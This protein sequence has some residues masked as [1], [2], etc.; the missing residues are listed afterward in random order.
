MGWILYCLLY[1]FLAGLTINLGYHRCLAHRSLRLPRFLESVLITFG[2]P[3]GTPI[4]WAGNHRYH[5]RY[6]DQENDPHSPRYGGFWHAHVGWYIGTANPWI[7][8][9]YAFAGPLRA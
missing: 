7:C 4:Q 5:H 8:I 1:Y 9:P 6:A 3:A 2:L